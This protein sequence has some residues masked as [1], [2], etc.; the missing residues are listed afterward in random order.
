MG[1]TDNGSNRNESI[2]REKVKALNVLNVYSN[3]LGL[4]IASQMIED[5]T[6][7]IPTIPLIL[8]KI[9]VKGNIITWDALNTQKT[10]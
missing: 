9:N 4:C 6:N 8:D 7:E 10:T 1:K 2:T 3:N 5:K